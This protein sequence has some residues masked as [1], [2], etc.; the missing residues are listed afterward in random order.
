MAVLILT[1]HDEEKVARWK[2]VKAEK[3]AQEAAE[4]RKAEDEKLKKPH[5]QTGNTV[6]TIIHAGICQYCALKHD[7]LSYEL[8]NPIWNGKYKNTHEFQCPVTEKW[9]AI[10]FDEPVEQS[11]QEEAKKDET[12]QA[13]A[14]SPK[15]QIT[16]ADEE[17]GWGG[18]W[19]IY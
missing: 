15:P 13:D 12:P 9:F 2:K 14:E 4:R 5:D 3:E 11:T 18:M 19:G 10:R 16:G 7:G 17:T 8:K 1:E 6:D